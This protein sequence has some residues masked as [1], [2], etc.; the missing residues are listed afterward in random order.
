MEGFSNKNLQENQQP[1]EDGDYIIAVNQYYRVSFGISYLSKNPENQ[2]EKYLQENKETLLKLANNETLPKIDSVDYAI[3]LSQL[4]GDIGFYEAEKND[5][6]SL[7]K[8]PLSESDLTQWKLILRKLELAT[9]LWKRIMQKI[10]PTETSGPSELFTQ[11]GKTV[12]IGEYSYDYQ[13]GMTKEDIR[14]FID[15]APKSLIEH[16]DNFM[17]RIQ[18]AL[19]EYAKETYDSD[20][21][22]QEKLGD[23]DTANKFIYKLQLIKDKLQQKV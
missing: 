9:D 12:H 21:H 18:N 7:H 5:F 6:A 19:R 4:A 2:D 22:N 23:L 3:A 15:L 17:F 11:L 1:K 14:S 13:S 20:K 16:I 10:E 8:I